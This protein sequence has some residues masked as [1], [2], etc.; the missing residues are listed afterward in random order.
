M[1]RNLEYSRSGRYS[2]DLS[3][4]VLTTAKGIAGDGYRLGGPAPYGFVRVLVDSSGKEI[5]DLPPGKK[6]DQRGCRVRVKPKD[7]G[8]IS[9]WLGMIE[10]AE[11]GLGAPAIADRLTARDIPAPAAGRGGSGTVSTCP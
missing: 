1:T 8:T 4:R 11:K 10:Q 7:C 5:E 3:D 6:V 9:D 2:C